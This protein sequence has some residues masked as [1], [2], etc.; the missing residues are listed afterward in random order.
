MAYFS[1]Q[2]SL[3]LPRAAVLTEL[4]KLSLISDSP[5]KDSARPSIVSDKADLKEFRM[6][7]R[8]ISG[9]HFSNNCES[10]LVH[11]KEL[12]TII[13]PVNINRIES[14]TM[15]ARPSSLSKR[16]SERYRDEYNKYKIKVYPTN[17]SYRYAASTAA[18]AMDFNKIRASSTMRCSPMK[19]KKSQKTKLME[20]LKSILK[21]DKKTKIEKVESP[22][23]K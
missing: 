13:R 22:V 2:Q 7:F 11:V 3:D 16:V 20:E 10:Q 6:S 14:E 23:E 19:N 18:S 1:N 8:S 21:V 12:S 5:S 15:I 4:K 9:N 17:N